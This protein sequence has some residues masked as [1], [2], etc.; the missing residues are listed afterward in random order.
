MRILI[1]ALL[2]LPPIPALAD[3]KP[4]TKRDCA[5]R[6]QI[7]PVATTQQG[8]ER[9]DRLPNARAYLTVYREVDRCPAPVIVAFGIAADRR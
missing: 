3:I 4:T 6:Q 5:V 9:L 8:F 1:A 2:L 7:V